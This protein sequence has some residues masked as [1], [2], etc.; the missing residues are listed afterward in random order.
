MGFPSDDELTGPATMS[1]GG[2]VKA[3]GCLNERGVALLVVLWIFIFLLVVA[4]DFSASVR[5][6]ATAAHRYSDET[7]GYYIALAGFERGVYEFL[8][9][10]TARDAL[11]TQKKA[12][13]FDGDWHEEA[14]GGGT[15]RVRWVDEGGKININRADEET[16]RRVFTNLGVEEPSKAILV[17]SIMDWRDPDDLHRTSGA[18]DEYYRSLT[19]PYT[20]KNGPFDTV[21][22]LLWVRGMTAE[23]FYG[24][25]DA[26]GNRGENAQRIGLR[27]IFTVDSPIDRVNLRTASGDVIHALTGIP[28]EKTRRFVEERKKLS[29]KTLADLLPLL[30]IGANDAAL[31]QFVFANP[32][33]VTVEAEGRPTQSQLSRRVK[34]VVRAA[35]GGRE[36]ELV[37]WV[38]RDVALAAR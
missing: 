26:G 21:E 38:D 14:L 25:G 18:E 9:Q 33:V 34:G 5:E 3:S 16:L 22:D 4:F 7:H 13:I 29:D 2:K 8:Q 11:G 15:L 32:A 12:D 24:Y 28:L 27:E 17:D 20:A 35:G 6:E 19:P 10:S 31:Q 36:F 1:L 37:R 23:L 30:G